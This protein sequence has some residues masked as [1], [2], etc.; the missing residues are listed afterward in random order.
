LSKKY[1]K[2]FF[3][4]FFFGKKNQEANEKKTDRKSLKRT[5]KTASETVSKKGS[6]LPFLKPPPVSEVGRTHNQ[7]D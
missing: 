6:M 1:R 2:K 5:L 7:I 4:P 3:G